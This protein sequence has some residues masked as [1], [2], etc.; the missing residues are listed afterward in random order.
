MDKKAVIT[1]AV[2]AVVV[3]VLAN[4]IRQLPVVDKLPTF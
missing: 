1:V 2:T 4:R 3:L